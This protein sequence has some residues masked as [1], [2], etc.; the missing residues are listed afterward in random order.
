MRLFENLNHVNMM[1]WEV[2]PSKRKIN[3]VISF[4][5]ASSDAIAEGDVIVTTVD[6]FAGVSCWAIDKIQERRKGAMRAFDYV[7]AE[8]SHSYRSPVEI[9]KFLDDSNSNKFSLKIRE[10][11]LS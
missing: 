1:M 3:N 2:N 6:G 4:Y 7:T 5:I 10:S 11:A 9:V 8:V